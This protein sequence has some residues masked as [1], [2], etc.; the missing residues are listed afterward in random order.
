MSCRWSFLL[1]HLL[2]GVS[3][4]AQ[5]D[6]SSGRSSHSP[7]PS[8][9]LFRE[10]IVV[11]IVYKTACATFIYTDLYCAHGNDTT[12]YVLVRT[13]D[14]VYCWPFAKGYPWAF[15]SPSP[16]SI[17]H[18]WI[19]RVLCARLTHLR[20]SLSPGWLGIF[21]SRF[22]ITAA[23]RSYI[24]SVDVFPLIALIKRILFYFAGGRLARQEQGLD[25][26]VELPAGS[27]ATK[28][29]NFDFLID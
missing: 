8:E 10:E 28:V 7:V 9:I 23:R 16:A 20:Y 1:Q 3:K 19:Y 2:K 4:L 6:S 29:R 25:L 21:S 14:Y 5:R 12:T 17:R 24:L 13:L 26:R 18:S 22:A 11:G 15:T 27:G